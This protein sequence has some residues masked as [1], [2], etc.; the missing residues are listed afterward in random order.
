MA[1]MPTSGWASPGPTSRAGSSG[2][3]IPTIF[4]SRAFAGRAGNRSRMVNSA[5]W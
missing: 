2:P 5:V 1:F 3:T 4:S